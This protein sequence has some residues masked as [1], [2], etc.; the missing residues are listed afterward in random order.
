MGASRVSVALDRGAQGFSTIDFAVVV[1]QRPKGP[2]L[3]G[4]DEAS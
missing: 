1:M 3:S 4:H 2:E